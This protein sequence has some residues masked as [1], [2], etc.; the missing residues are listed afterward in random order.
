M[1]SEITCLF[2]LN[3]KPGKLDVFKS[4]IA[5]IVPI[6]AK[7]SGTIVYEYSVNEIGDKAQI[8]ERYRDSD[9]IVSHVDESFGPFAEEFLSFVD[10][11]SLVVHG[12]PSA[13]ARNRLSAF[14]P[15]YFLPFNGC[16]KW[17]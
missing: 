4:L 8:V 10:V 17:A 12:N 13:D 7:E 9:A 1:Y 6:V 15:E 5:E 14:S 16:K 11:F 3:V 2:S